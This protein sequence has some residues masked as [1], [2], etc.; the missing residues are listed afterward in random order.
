MKLVLLK[1]LISALGLLPL[2]WARA[3]GA[4]IGSVAYR[5][6]IRM[7]RVARTNI[8][9]CLGDQ[10][11]GEILV[12][13]CMRETGK[14][15]AETGV[16]WSWPLQKAAG[17]LHEARNDALFDEALA[18]GN[19]VIIVLLHHGNWEMINAYLYQPGAP[20]AAIYKPPKDKAIDHWITKT[21]EKSGL[22]LYPTGRE[23]AHALSQR[24]GEGGVVLFAPDQE[25]G[26]KS[27][28]FAP[29]FGIDA[30]TG[31]FT[32]HLLQENP[33][34]VPLCT[35]VMRT[36]EGFQVDFESM[37][38]GMHASEP[39]EAAAALNQ[40]IEPVIRH[41]PQQYQWGYK[42]FKKRPPGQARIYD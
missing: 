36:R 9:L 11:G 3:L 21:R 28:V 13:A 15:L 23:G 26:R 19:G 30:L 25:P 16:T 12:R 24:L 41:Q 33:R 14:T 2:K 31:T 37:L 10:A 5:L 40:S 22:A 8:G 1:C 35:C 42:R 4:F 20:F 27:G 6:N 38:P 32:H 39:R 34:A 7:T 18:A 29:L 17:L